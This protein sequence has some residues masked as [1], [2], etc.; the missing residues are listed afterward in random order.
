MVELSRAVEDYLKT[1]YHLTAR[2]GSATTGGLAHEMGVASPSATAM[3]RRLE[4]G[5]LLTRPDARSLRLTAA[6]EVA[7]LRVVRRHRLLETFLARVLDVPWDEVHDEAEL[8]EH[9]LSERLEERI[10]TKL[11]HPAFDPH[12]DPIPPRH[13]THCED[14]GRP[15]R[16]TAPGCRF[17]VQRV[18]DRDSAALRHLGLLGVVP[19]AVLEVEEQAPFGGPLWIRVGGQRHPLGEPLVEL[20]HG[21]IEGEGHDGDE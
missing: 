1:V 13:G 12:G 20:V 7:A 4:E 19:G 18:S 8:L 16:G 14:W 3:V 2:G 6:G 10:D 11:G 9:A 15:L 21:T 5:G 17:R